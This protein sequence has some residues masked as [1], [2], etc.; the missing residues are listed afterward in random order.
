M[1][2]EPEG[3]FPPITSGVGKNGNTQERFES[4]GLGLPFNGGYVQHRPY[5]HV[6]FWGARWNQGGE[7]AEARENLLNFYRWVSGSSYAAILKQYFDFGGYISGESALTSYT[8]PRAFPAT[9]DIQAVK[10]EVHYS[11]QNHPGWEGHNYEDQ[12]VVVLPPN[13]PVNVGAGN[14]GKEPCGLH[15]WD[16]A[17]WQVSETLVNWTPEHC[18]R[19]L[20]PKYSMQVTASHEW[21]E[22]A[23]DPIPIE[24]Y[25]GWIWSNNEGEIG[26]ICNV[27]TPAEHGEAAPGI[28][29]A[30]LADDYLFKANKT[31]CVVQDA[32][33]VRFEV[34]TGASSISPHSASLNGSVNPAGWP[35]AYQFE[36]VGPGGVQKLPAAFTPAG[37]GAFSSVAV[38]ANVEGLTANT[39]YHVRLKAYGDLTR[40]LMPDVYGNIAIFSGGETQF[41]TPDWR[42]ISTTEAATGVKAQNAVLHAT[43]NPQGTDTH[44]QFEYGATT[45]YG[46]SVPVPAA[47]IGAGVAGVAVENAIAGLTEATTYHYRVTATNSEGTSVGADREFRTPG[48]PVVTTEPALYANTFE[49]ELSAA[50]NPN[51]AATKYQ[52]EYGLTTSYGSKIPTTSEGIGSGV[53]AIAVGKYLS[54]L[55]RSATYHF[56]VVAENEVGVSYGADKAFTTLPPCKGPEQKCVWS[57]QSSPSPASST[58]DRLKGMSCRSSTMCL[59]VG[60]D[61]ARSNSF[62][63][64]WNGSEWKV[65]QVVPG[66][67]KKVS[68]PT[69]T[70]C[71]SVGASA[72]GG[73]EY[74]ESGPAAG[75]WLSVGH[76][77]PT[78]SGGT[79]PVL[80]SISC[81]SESAC[82]AV[83]SY[84]AST[85]YK[86]LVERWNGSSWAIQTAPNPS[87]GNASEAMLSVSCFG[88]ASCTS[89]GKAGGKPVAER[90]NGSEWSLSSMPNP[91]GASGAALGAVSCAAVTSC[92]AVGSFHEGSGFE[93]TLAERYN[94]SEW[95]IVGTPNPSEAKV[96]SFL[97][98]VSCLSPN[99]CF[100][101][102]FYGPN[103]LEAKTVAESWSPSSWT[104]QSSPNVAGAK[105]SALADLACTSS[106]A[107]TAVGSGHPGSVEG[108]GLVTLVERYE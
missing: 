59:A 26:D 16:G 99:S 65:A 105:E 4:Y 90:W 20:P 34:A 100:A 8:D 39:E 108:Q 15:L 56:R 77:P 74:W 22:S 97:T 63:E 57:L 98:G 83:G 7:P 14:G 45:G 80:N 54:G 106:I 61:A 17:S 12:Y 43:V 19:G 25:W 104:L 27:G 91:A 5:V 11:I 92:M 46:T 3:G 72:T 107:C 76:T 35:A 37:G 64:L 102:G 6:I 75:S 73:L 82:T 13:A 2:P 87:E 21:A 50:V 81:T 31:P 38:S 28:F 86:P 78:P 33:P 53:G 68:C 88:S 103:Y 55:Q 85:E 24:G 52:F 30:K 66:E 69:E 36:F 70:R 79:S 60:R 49:P 10:D 62:V 96:G 23:T 51:G 71:Y 58:E 44:Y 89:V 94:G 29:V 42:P 1:S 18:Q 84:Y 47:D 101:V 93:K 40:A 32:S 41:T 95:T 48:K 9:I 67:M